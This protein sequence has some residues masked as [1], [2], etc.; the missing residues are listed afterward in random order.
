MTKSWNSIFILIVLLLFALLYSFIIANKKTNEISVN[1]LI[2]KLSAKPAEITP[3]LEVHPEE[4][5]ISGTMKG[6]TSEPEA[7]RV[8][9]PKPISMEDVLKLLERA[10]VDWQA[11]PTQSTIVMVKPTPFFLTL[12]GPMMVF[13]LPVLLFGFFY[14][15]MVKQAQASGGQALSFGKS[16]A[17]L[18]TDKPNVSFKD[19]A[20]AA[21]AVEELHEI[22]E[23]LKEKKKFISLGA[24]I[25]KGVLLVGPPGCGKTLLARAIAGEA[26][27]PFF[28]M[29][30]SDFVEMFVGVGASRVRDLFEQAKRHAPAIVFI[31]EIDAVGRQRGTGLGGGHDER[32]Q[33]LNQL[34]VE[35]D[36]FDTNSGVILIA[37]TNRPDVLDPA[38]LR[39]GRF[40]RRVTVDEPDYR[41]R[42]E[43]LIIHS[44]EVPL[45]DNVDLRVIS[46]RTPGFSGAD[47]RN[48]V[49]EA[50]I[51]AARENVKKVSMH[52]FDEAT[53]RVI[54][55]PQRKSRLVSEKERKMTA[56]HEAG[57]A[58]AHFFSGADS[59]LHKITILPRGRAGG[60]NLILPNEEVHYLTRTDMLQTIQI[61]LGGRVADELIFGEP[62]TGASDD[63]NRVTR[64][65]RAMV[66]EYG[67]SEKLG[68]IIFG[69]RHGGSVFLGR[70]FMEERNYSEEI[71]YQIDQ[72]VNEIVSKACEDVRVMLREHQPILESIAMA[73]LER[74]VLDADEVILL[75]NG[76]SLPPI[77][78]PTKRPPTGGSPD[79]TDEPARDTPRRE[80][81]I[82]GLAPSPS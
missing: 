22:V 6:A 39:P 37:A 33:T 7:F 21:E 53:E 10:D 13:V 80:P 5:Y 69:A 60:Y 25:P 32:E 62:T 31:D 67:M 19:V 54:A 74:E 59:T 36:G 41:G 40:D 16:R 55:G 56:Y 47:L 14:F 72:E 29:S 48:L 64:I 9:L 79:A 18:L 4:G 1:E 43:I 46:R 12:I 78:Q 77:E 34:L 58:V 70:D 49:N 44:R 30:G 45:D 2:F 20:G 73:L 11:D 27:V 24:K 28:H 66:M 42:E 8:N 35:M 65:A 15:F 81:G 75:M 17:K 76:K 23:F 3:P 52:H 82:G 26:G 38:L 51:L 61:A 57:H 63:L 71:A 68:T 50:A